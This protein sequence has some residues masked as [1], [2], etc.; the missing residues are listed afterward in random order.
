VFIGHF[1]VGFAA[2]RI[3][4]KV[5]LGTLI[6]AAIL[7][8][9]LWIPFFMFG[10]EHVT[11]QPGIMIAN[12]LNLV[13]I[14]F[15]HSLAMDAVWGGLFAGLYFISRKDNR[16]AWILCAVV[17]SHWFLDF[18]A[19]R[20]DMPLSPGIDLRFGLGL[21]NSRAAT[22]LVEG[23]LWSAAVFL[24]AAATRPRGRAGVYAF[25]FMIIVL[26]ALWLVSLRGDPPP[27]LPALAIVNTVFI[28]IV[29]A[30]AYW[31]NRS[32]IANRMADRAD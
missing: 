9:V 7:S 13:Y 17:V 2:K 12:S 16:G 31:M 21:W 24:Y 6:L 8:D 4:P 22:F 1:A 15:S 28:A 3:A 19:H 18:A 20:P 23:L 27:S 11:I 32:R 26:T 29:L 10:L 30:W 14:P 5:S 25:W